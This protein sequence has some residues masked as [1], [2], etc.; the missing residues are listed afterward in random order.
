MME[1]E[2]YHPSYQS[3]RVDGTTKGKGMANTQTQVRLLLLVSSNRK[4][5]RTTK[6]SLTYAVFLFPIFPVF[7]WFLKFS[8]F[9]F[10]QSEFHPFSTDF[11]TFSPFLFAFALIKNI[12]R[13]IPET[14]TQLGLIFLFVLLC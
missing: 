8:R 2:E 5:K 14:R 10:P 1:R 13:A 7:L 12:Q 9:C 11:Q 3:D 4:E 6:S